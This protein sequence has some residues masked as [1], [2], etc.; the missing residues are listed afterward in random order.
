MKSK[1]VRRDQRLTRF[2]FHIFWDF[3][4]S[5]LGRGL[6]NKRDQPSKVLVSFPMFCFPETLTS[7]LQAEQ[8][9][10]LE[11]LVSLAYLPCLAIGSSS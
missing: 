2:L 1:R 11:S 7:L 6:S 9:E 4:F 10:F 5:A 8:G 3:T